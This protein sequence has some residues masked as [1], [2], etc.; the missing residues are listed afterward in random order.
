MRNCDTA[1]YHAKDRG[2]NSYQF[3]SEWMNAASFDRLVFEER[4]RRAVER[5]ELELHYQPKVE[6]A[7]GRLTGF[8]AL[9][10]WNDEELGLVPPSEFVTVAEEIGLIHELGRWVLRSAAT[11]MRGWGEAGLPPFHV[12]VNVSGYQVERGGLVAL[13]ADVL[14]ETCLDPSRLDLEI[15]ESVLLSDG[16]RAVETLEDLRG[17]GV[18]LSLDDFGTGYSSLSYLRRLPIQGL[19]IDRS[20]VSHLADG[21]DDASLTAA[22]ISMA[23]ALGLRVIAEGVE[24]EGQREILHELGC[25]ELQGYLV[26]AAVPAEEVP[27]LVREL[28]RKRPKR[29]PTA[30]RRKGRQGSSRSRRRAGGSAEG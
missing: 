2:R 12:S 15:T 9:L 18:T 21:S 1:M 4:L 29:R 27:R 25:D 6:V 26:S 5:G 3:Y 23:R 16:E 17:L 10:R 19:K 8:E 20:F 14:Q 22:I 11:Q 28:A 30:A 7:S 24:H 13:V